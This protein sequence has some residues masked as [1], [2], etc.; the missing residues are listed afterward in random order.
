M[1][2]TFTI[3]IIIIT[4]NFT[5]SQNIFTGDKFSSNSLI[6]K[7]KPS[8]KSIA[9]SSKINDEKI[10]SFFNQINA[11]SIKQKFPN[12]IEPEKSNSL[13]V[14]ISTIYE[15]QFNS[16]TDVFKIVNYLSSLEYIEYAQP[17]YYPKI[18]A[19]TPNDLLITN[20]YYL[21]NIKAY[22]AWDLP[23]GKGDSSIVVGIT[24]TGVDFTHEDLSENIYY[25]Y[26]DPIDG[27]DNDNDGFI[28]NFR[29]WDVANN[30]NNPMV[31]IS[32]LIPVHIR[33]HGTYVAGCSSARTNNGKGIAG[34]GYHTKF[35]PIKI[36]NSDGIINTGYEG[37]VYAADHGCHII[38]CSWGGTTGHPY[39]Q[40]I[41]NYAT[42]NR[43]CLVI[44]AAGNSNN[45]VPFYPASYENVLNVAGT[46]S[47]DVKWN[48]SCFGST[49]DISA[50][51]ESVFLTG[52]NNT[53]IN[54]WGTSFASPIAAG[55]AG[56]VKHN[57]PN[58]SPLQLLERIRV[59]SDN[60][61]S[62]NPNY[63]E[64]LGKGRINL[65]RA[66]T[67][68]LTPSVR[69]INYNFN[70][71]S[72]FY[73]S[74]DTVS[75]TGDFYNY[76]D[77]VND[78]TITLSSTSQFITMIQ[79]S[80]DIDKI[81]T[82]SNYN[83]STSPFEFIIKDN[84]PYDEK[85]HIRINYNSASDNYN[86]FQ[87]ISITL[88]PSYYNL[89]INNI[90]TTITANG[91]IGYHSTSP[92]IGNGF[93]F[94]NSE[95]WLYESGIMIANSNSSV[96]NCIRGDKDFYVVS[97]A[98]ESNNSSS[99]FKEIN[100][101]FKE[102][103]DSNNFNVLI[104]QRSLAWNEDNY[105]DFVIFEY[106]L[107]NQNAFPITNLYFGIFA[108]WDIMNPYLNKSDY[109]SNLKLA[110]TF[111]SEN[112]SPYMG[113]KLLSSNNNF[114]YA[115]DNLSGGAGGVDISNGYNNEEKYIT[116]SN[117]RLKAGVAGSGT[118]VVDVISYGPSIIN[119]NDTLRLAF[120][121]LGGENII[122]LFENATNA[123]TKYNSL[124][125]GI[126]S[127]SI[128]DEISLFPNPSKDYISIISKNN[129]NIIKIEITDISGK[130]IYFN[131]NFEN[132]PIPI[133]VFSKGIY[134]VKIST[135]E[136][137]IYKSL[138]VN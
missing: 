134:N 91:R 39:G 27:L 130:S 106:D 70:S 21:N 68:P 26:N 129:V 87:Y 29:G 90:A 79:S 31:E 136:S 24:D 101:E 98:R 5:Y 107:I 96:S 52:S 84:V 4:I 38:N 45:D 128:N 76:L 74:G 58:F 120:A 71:N 82:S 104:K 60:I 36:L 81:N 65:Y 59:T 73:L 14:D 11:T 132:K 124:Y 109:D 121:L 77:T 19:F 115:I 54:G 32:D 33:N 63:I 119:A 35:L 112:S 64:K 16:S 105:K 114:R 61:D 122:K 47:A 56:I 92:A 78:L 22:D 127:I 116:L 30:D 48:N 57:F 50:P 117:N 97:P 118:D 53:Y 110:Y 88:N 25:N 133:S 12:S 111:S 94:N 72:G 138:I 10:S 55:C 1:K 8:Y 89:N 23:G 125:S 2:S 37:I 40:D 3:I 51:G 113:I 6:F 83:N 86:D 131:R 126:N 7:I 67:D 103:S 135:N 80:L 85:I 9:E 17:I 43:N 75:L 34:P 137:V 93:R 44:A 66:I 108:D 41:I 13:Q 42:F 49:V 95:S 69:F 15:L 28:D 20:Q 123:Q 18:F 102:V 46:N 62:L 100:S 99:L